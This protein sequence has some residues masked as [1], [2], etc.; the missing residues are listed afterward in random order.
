MQDII[1][2]L[3]QAVN[4]E[5]K[6]E[7]LSKLP[8]GFY[9]II[10][11]RVK[12]LK[13]MELTASTEEAKN[14]AKSLRKLIIEIVSKLIDIRIRKMVEKAL[15]GEAF[16]ADEY[17]KPLIVPLMSFISNAN[18]LK[19]FINEGK[20]KEL[21]VFHKSAP[22]S[23]YLVQFLKPVDKFVGPDLIEYGP[24]EAGD[25]ATIPQENA[26][27]LIDKNIVMKVGEV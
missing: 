13:I 6:E 4:G 22:I 3:N 17:E 9:G 14:A 1:N 23:Y 26:K 5:L 25:L 2:L 21:E 18:R 11:L 16:E 8:V 27:I 10:A 12:Q 15:A 24:F 19:S 20:I 7:N